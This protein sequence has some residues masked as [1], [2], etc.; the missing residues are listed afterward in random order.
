MAPDCNKGFTQILPT[1]HID[2][3]EEMATFIYMRQ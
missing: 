3:Q 1:V 2:V